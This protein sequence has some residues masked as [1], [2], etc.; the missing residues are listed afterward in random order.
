MNRFAKALLSGAALALMIVPT[1]EAQLSR[2][3]QTLEANT[4]VTL[5]GTVE[6][7]P[8]TNSFTLRYT[9]GSI[10]VDTNDAWPDLFR[11]DAAEILKPGDQVT[12]TGRVDDA[13]F[14]A[15]EIDAMSISHKGQTYSRVYTRGADA[16]PL[17][18]MWPYY[19]WDAARVDNDNV[20]VSGVVSE[21]S[22][23]NE[24]EMKFGDRTMK[25]DT[26]DLTL[27][28]TERLRAGDRV[29]VF[30]KV[31]D[32]WFNTR[33]LRADSLVRAHLYESRVAR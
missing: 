15:K 6:G 20:S 5:S 33:T 13:L 30:G 22:G 16:D 32:T 1:A 14:S 2:A 25:V 19:G 7:T 31:D 10:R 12:V 24:F 4:Y 28:E 26:S 8:E 3:D 23:N 29:T 17:F 11:K 18:K 27:A 21:I 9:G